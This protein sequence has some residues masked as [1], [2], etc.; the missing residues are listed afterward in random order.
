MY[1][2]LKS[3]QHYEDR[4]DDGTVDMCQSGER[5]VNGTFKIME[6]KLPKQELIERQAGWYL[7]YS[8]LYFWLVESAAAA[9]HE[10]RDTA[11]AK[12]MAED[13][14]KDERLASAHIAGGTYCRS[15]GKDMRVM[16]KD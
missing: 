5:T 10:G 9:R 2:Y 6:K 11:I 4:Y 8:K 1:E 7:E 3:R 14:K 15:C 12:W 16:S 13:Q